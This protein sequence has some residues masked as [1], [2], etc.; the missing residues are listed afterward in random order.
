MAFEQKIVLAA[1]SVVGPLGIGRRLGVDHAA[2]ART[3][4]AMILKRR[5]R[6]SYFSAELFAD[7]AWDI[8]LALTL[9]ESRQYRLHI[10][11][12][13]ERVA[14]PTTTV[15][16]WVNTLIEEGLVVRRAAVNDK[17]RIYIELTSDAYARMVD[18]CTLTI[19][20]AMAA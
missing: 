7:P 11:Q 19:P 4:D 1:A 9:A 3:V 15:G 2:M 13:C 20:S 18:Y 12:L 16:R 14:A 6:A 5:D 8:L 17:R 10:S